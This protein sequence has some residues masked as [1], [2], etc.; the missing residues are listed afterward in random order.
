MAKGEYAEAALN[1]L[2]ITRKWPESELLPPALYKAGHCYEIM[3][4]PEMAKQYFDRLIAE[5]PESAEAE[6]AKQRSTEAE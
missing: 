5:H 3:E 4:Q 6:L 2:S 1:Y